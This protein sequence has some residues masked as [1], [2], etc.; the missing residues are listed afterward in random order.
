M[1]LKDIFHRLPITLVEDVSICLEN[2]FCI[3]FKCDIW[4]RDFYFLFEISFIFCCESKMRTA[5]ALFSI[6][7]G[8]VDAHRKTQII[9]DGYH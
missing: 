7:F 6:R 2:N 8:S 5:G 4:P 1:H 9:Y 3:S